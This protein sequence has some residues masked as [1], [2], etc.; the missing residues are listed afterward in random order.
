MKRL[1]SD[2]KLKDDK[3]CDDDGRCIVQEKHEVGVLNYHLDTTATMTNSVKLD[4]K[5]KI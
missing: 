1:P 5:F 2:E 3:Q 4:G